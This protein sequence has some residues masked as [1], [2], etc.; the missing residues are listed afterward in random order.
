ME[1]RPTK[2]KLTRMHGNSSAGK[3]RSRGTVGQAPGHWTHWTGSK[4]ADALLE[5]KFKFK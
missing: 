2:R 3:G 1:S 4:R 5:K